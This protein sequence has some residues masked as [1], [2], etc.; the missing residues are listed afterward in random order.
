M[1]SGF[2][3][4][5]LI[6]RIAELVEDRS[7]RGIAATISRLISDGGL[8]PGTRL[9]TVR[10]L[11]GRLGVSPTTVSQAW[12]S[13][14]QV[15][16]VEARGRNGT[17]VLDHRRPVEPIRFRRVSEGH[18]HY[19]LDLSTGIPDPELL[20]DLSRV[21][22]GVGHD[23]L[24][25]SYLDDPVL[26]DLDEL[27][28]AMW[29]F[30]PE[31]LTVVD[32]AM[33]ALDRVASAALRLGDRVLV[34]NPCFPP[35]LDL[36]E[37]LGAEPV[38]LAMDD[39][40]IVLSALAEGLHRAPVA[41]FLQPRAHNPTGVSMSR[42]RA[43]RL[44]ILLRQPEVLIVEDDHAGDI[45]TSPLVSL[46]AQLPGRTIHIRSFSKSHGPDLRLAAVGGRGD[47]VTKLVSRRLLGAGWS[48]RLL[49]AVLVQLLRDPDA[50]ASVVAARE[51]YAERRRRLTE[52][53]SERGVRTTGYDGINL[54]V[55]V[56]DERSALLTLA[57]KGVGVAPGTPFLV[58]PTA[59][60]HI[61][62]T[63]GL[64]RDGFEEL[65]D[66]LALAAGKG[67]G[68]RHHR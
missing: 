22:A 13:L 39:E 63:V 18:G 47:V 53:L 35:L 1:T 7:P 4:A 50:S 62:V 44:A 31:A 67:R 52:A 51:A 11:A 9:P 24:T 36:L 33:D 19:A 42:A 59:T 66:L 48:S 2:R 58:A 57:T 30:K 45:S 43:R 6:D 55:E 21:L 10:V 60:Q 40:G 56:S 5:F 64:V 54:W 61:R 25:T 68:A 14:A 46:G 29:P 20:P 49:Q 3:G 38:G 8:S 23:Q 37:K 34:E 16:A 27:L 17:Y 28:R 15:G 26:G 65:A 12:Q 41:L 32:G